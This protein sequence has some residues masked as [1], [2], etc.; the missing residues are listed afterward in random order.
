MQPATASRA[1]GRAVSAS[2]NKRLV[3]VRSCFEFMRF[4]FMRI[5]L[6]LPFAALEELA[7]HDE[8][9][10]HEEHG[11]HRG[12]VI[13]PP[14]TPVPIA[15]WLAEPAPVAITSGST[16]QMK[17]SEVIR[18]GRKR[19]CA[20]FERRLDQRLALR[21]QVLGELDDQDGV[22]LPRGR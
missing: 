2:L 19:R 6:A 12:A 16:P 1:S 4:E 18:I 20:G 22:L 14:I 13:M 15:R 17:A 5:H 3:M 11:Q 7:H 8:E 21:A 9:H 10:R